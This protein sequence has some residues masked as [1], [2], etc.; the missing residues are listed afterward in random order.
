MSNPFF[1]AMSN[2]FSVPVEPINVVPYPGGARPVYTSSSGSSGVG[3]GRGRKVYTVNKKRYVGMD[4]GK[5]TKV[6][7]LKLIQEG[8][9]V[10]YTP[11]T[12]SKPVTTAKQGHRRRKCEVWGATGNRDLWSQAMKQ[13]GGNSTLASSMYRENIVPISGKARAVGRGIYSD[14]KLGRKANRL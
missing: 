2:P 13:A 3:I 10:P 14:V 8:A 9:L 7:K 1:G 4:Y 11:K 5:I 6:M 12:N